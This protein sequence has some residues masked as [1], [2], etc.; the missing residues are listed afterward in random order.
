MA[1]KVDERSG[2]HLGGKKR[3]K[4]KDAR[5]GVSGKKEG[6][7]RYTNVVN[8][9]TKSREARDRST[10]IR[11]SVNKSISHVRVL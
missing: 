8:I 9:T 11:Q 5:N 2:E 3:W 4:D 7:R 1:A 6:Y 10:R